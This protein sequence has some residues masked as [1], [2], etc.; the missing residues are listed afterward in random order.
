MSERKNFYS[1]ILLFGEYALMVGSQALSIPYESLQ[2]TFVFGKPDSSEFDYKSHFKKYA[3]YL[4]ELSQEGKLV[5]KLDISRLEKDIDNGLMFESNIPLGYGLGSSGAL[6]AAVYDRYGLDKIPANTNLSG[7]KL[8][9]LKKTMAAMESWFHGKSSGLDPVVC[10][11]Q[12]AVMAA[13]DNQLEIVNLPRFGTTS[14]G[15]VF[16]LD[17]GM[18]GETQPL[19]NYFVK[20]CENSGF[21]QSIHSELI[22]LNTQCI[23]AYLTGDVETLFPCVKKLSAF[24]LQ[25]FHPMI[26][27]KLFPAWKQGLENRQYFLKLCGSGGGGMMLGFTCNFEQAKTNLKPFPLKIVQQF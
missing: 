5:G 23:R 6:V 13:K 9:A 18:T 27:E 14:G 22:P 15:A 10:Y 20:Q 3:G 2:G 11:L 12:K 19:V 16:L 24:T 4:R 7:E 26:P 8:V 1:K 17:T 25:H 21:F